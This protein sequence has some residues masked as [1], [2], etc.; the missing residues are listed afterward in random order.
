MRAR[1][2]P[3]QSRL[4]PEKEAVARWNG[5]GQYNSWNRLRGALPDAAERPIGPGPD[6]VNGQ[7]SCRE[8]HRVELVG[9]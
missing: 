2:L 6:Q 3:W 7:A 1:R 8:H 9:S 4:K 5:Q